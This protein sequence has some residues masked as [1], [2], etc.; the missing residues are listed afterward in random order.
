MKSDL[1]NSGYHLIDDKSEELEEIRAELGR[2]RSNYLWA[3]STILYWE[4]YSSELISTINRLKQVIAKTQGADNRRDKTISALIQVIASKRARIAELELVVLALQDERN[5][6]LALAAGARKTQPK[7][8]KLQK[9]KKTVPCPNCNK[10]FRTSQGQKQHERE[11]CRTNCPVCQKIIKSLQG[12]ASH[13]TNTDCGRATN[14][15][16]KGRECPVC[17]KTLHDTKGVLNHILMTKCYKAVIKQIEPPKKPEFKKRTGLC[18]CTGCNKCFNPYVIQSDVSCGGI[19]GSRL[20]NLEGFE[21]MRG[22]LSCSK[23]HLAAN[24][25]LVRVCACKYCIA[26]PVASPRRSGLT[27]S[28]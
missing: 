10:K 6:A 8:T 23:E 11:A 27:G 17:A 13:M 25:D 3:K 24:P 5:E 20:L 22:C 7:K 18:E 15:N 19:A 28:K 2:I 26:Y 12:V 9:P 1:Y 14:F 16:I 4:K 21:V